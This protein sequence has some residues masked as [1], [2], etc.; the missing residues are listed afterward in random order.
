MPEINGVELAKKIRDW[1]IDAKIVFLTAY[2]NYAR[3]GYKVKAY[4]YILKD[5]YN[6][7]VFLFR[8]E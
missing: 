3:S 6:N 7:F 4:D 1:N 2:E 8:Q 5:S